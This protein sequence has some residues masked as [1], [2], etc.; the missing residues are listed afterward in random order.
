MFQQIK[1]NASIAIIGVLVISLVIAAI[2]LLSNKAQ[3]ALT[4]SKLATAELSVSMLQ[5]DLNTV[6]ADLVS[7]EQ[8]K[9][10]LRLDAQRTVALMSQREN[11]RSQVERQA[12][13]INEQTNQ[14]IGAANN[15]SV[16]RWVN[17]LVPDELNRLLKHNAYCSHRDSSQDRI[18]VAATG[19]SQPLQ[20]G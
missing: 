19:V 18:C 7:A 14:I 15:E 17:D 2:S 1:D 11:E 9:A 3:L 8:E 10:R 16:T 5:T 12:A 20:S 13:D 4:E 6:T